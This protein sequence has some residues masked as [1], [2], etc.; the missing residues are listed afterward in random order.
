LVRRIARSLSCCAKPPKS[1]SWRFRTLYQ[2]WFPCLRMSCVALWILCSILSISTAITPP[3][4]SASS[5]QVACISGS[6]VSSCGLFQARYISPT[7]GDASIILRTFYDIPA[8]TGD[9]AQIQSTKG[10]VEKEP[11]Q[12]LSHWRRS[13]YTCLLGDGFDLSVETSLLVLNIMPRGWKL[14]IALC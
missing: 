2:I 7:L 12:H 5:E 4:G 6:N 13:C 3:Q 1:R 8:V 9:K 10:K 11:S 14:C